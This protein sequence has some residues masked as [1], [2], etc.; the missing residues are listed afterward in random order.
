MHAASDLSLRWV[1][2]VLGVLLQPLVKLVEG[3]C[4]HLV[5]GVFHGL[6]K[7]LAIDDVVPTRFR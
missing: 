4:L 2:D 6:S 1:A 7:Y 5:V 3:E